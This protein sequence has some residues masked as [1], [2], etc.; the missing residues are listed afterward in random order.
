MNTID[1]LLLDG[2]AEGQ[3][4][5]ILLLH[6]SGFFGNRR[7]GSLFLNDLFGLFGLRLLILSNDE[8]ADAKGHKASNHEESN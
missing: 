6:R 1:E 2:F 3:R 8:I 4:S 7:S 5:G